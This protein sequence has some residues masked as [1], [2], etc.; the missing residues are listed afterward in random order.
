MSFDIDHHI[1]VF[2]R[3]ADELLVESEL[4]CRRTKWP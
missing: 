3:G 1:A 2:R 4:R